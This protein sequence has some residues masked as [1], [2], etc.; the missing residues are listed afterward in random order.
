MEIVAKFSDG[1]SATAALR[2]QLP[3]VLLLDILMPGMNGID[4]LRNIASHASVHALVLCS[5]LTTEQIV[6]ILE[7][8]GRGAISKQE[9]S[10]LIPAIR[11]VVAGRYWVNSAAVS[12]VVQVLN[13]LSRESSKSQTRPYQLTLREMQIVRLITEGMTNRD[14]GRDLSIT[15]ETVKRHLTNIFEKVGMSNRLELA[16]FAINHNLVRKG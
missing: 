16:M 7:L 14:I 8:G 13:E 3:D 6:E 12:N 2:D 11:A 4:V 9:V 10:Q 15:E 1:K 5:S